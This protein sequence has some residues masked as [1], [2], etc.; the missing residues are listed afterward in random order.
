MENSEKVQI[1]LAEYSALREELMYFINAQRKFVTLMTSIAFGQSLFIFLRDDLQVEQL[2]FIYLFII[3]FL[4]F[5][6]MVSALECASKVLLVADYIHKGIKQQLGVFFETNEQFF[7]WEEHKNK[8][9]R[10]SRVTLKIL[11]YS[12]WYTFSVGVLL[13]FGLGVYFLRKSNALDIIQLIVASVLCILWIGISIRISRSFNEI[14]GES[15]H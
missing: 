12:K 14:D 15:I 5:V 1:I 11:D 13:S 3:P 8:T 2:A 7:E 4:I 6:L 10:V 9:S